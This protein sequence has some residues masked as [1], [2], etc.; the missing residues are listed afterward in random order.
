MDNYESTTTALKIPFFPL[1]LR[2]PAGDVL[3]AVMI[4]R[5]VNFSR[6]DCLLFPFSFSPILSLSL[7]SQLLYSASLLMT[8]DH[9]LPSPRCS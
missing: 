7:F 5:T 1:G 6:R 4:V 2:F 3:D 8:N 9:S